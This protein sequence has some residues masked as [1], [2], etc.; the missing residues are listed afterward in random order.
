MRGRLPGP[1]FFFYGPRRLRGLRVGP[2]SDTT[3][4]MSEPGWS[5]PPSPAFLNHVVEVRKKGDWVPCPK[6][7]VRATSFRSPGRPAEEGPVEVKQEGAA[8]ATG[9]HPDE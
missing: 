5:F 2:K 7:G 4:A 8:V 3:A 9:R 1:A 6:C